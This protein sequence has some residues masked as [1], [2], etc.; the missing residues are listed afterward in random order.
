MSPPTQ[1]DTQPLASHTPPKSFYQSCMPSLGSGGG[2]QRGKD[3]YLTAAL[4]SVFLALFPKLKKLGLSF[5]GNQQKELPGL[6]LFSSGRMDVKY[7]SFIRG[8]WGLA[9]LPAPQGPPSCEVPEP[10]PTHLPRAAAAVPSAEGH[11]PVTHPGY[12]SLAVPYSDVSYKLISNVSQC[13]T[14]TESQH[15][16]LP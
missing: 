16:C 9:A 10:A 15:D 4:L 1:G 14:Y 5:S 11:G 13:F 12:Q 3:F 7:S 8:F 6:S 2:S